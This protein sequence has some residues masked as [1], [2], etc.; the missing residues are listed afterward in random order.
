M[1]VRTVRNK[2]IEHPENQDGPIYCVSSYGNAEIGPLLRWVRQ[3]SDNSEFQDQGLWVNARE[4]EQNLTE[5]IN[6]ALGE[7]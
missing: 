6:A 5:K 3:P 4:F 2:L 1:G 7:S